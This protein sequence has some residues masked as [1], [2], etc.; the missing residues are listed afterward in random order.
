MVLASSLPEEV[1][2]A[3][4]H[5]FGGLAIVAAPREFAL[6][7]TLHH[8]FVLSNGNCISAQASLVQLAYQAPV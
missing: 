4:S 8:F 6:P 2:P 7:L 3:R 5:G 1:V